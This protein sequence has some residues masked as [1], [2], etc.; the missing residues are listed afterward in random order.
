MKLCSADGRSLL[1]P[2]QHVPPTRK[3]LS[4]PQSHVAAIL[5]LT[6]SPVARQHIRLCF[7]GCFR[8][9][10]FRSIAR[11]KF[12]TIVASKTAFI[13]MVDG[14]TSLAQ[15]CRVRI[16]SY[17]LMP[18][19]A[20]SICTGLPTGFLLVF[21]FVLRWS[22]SPSI[23][24]R[25]F[26]SNLQR[27]SYGQSRHRSLIDGYHQHSIA[28]EAVRARLPASFGAGSDCIIFSLA[29]FF[30]F[31]ERRRQTCFPLGEQGSCGSP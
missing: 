13:H 22:I 3:L 1:T 5:A 24:N 12:I 9:W 15:S 6:L 21:P 29:N 25:C 31:V 30:R 27:K 23:R 4:V 14:F 26:S 19:R 8:I 20:H 10:A 11:R 2:L 16:R 17:P 18:T 28:A 7:A